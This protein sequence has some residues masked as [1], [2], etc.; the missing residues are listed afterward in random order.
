MDS[1]GAKHFPVRSLPDHTHARTYTYVHTC[2]HEFARL[3][4]RP[5]AYPLLITLEN[6]SLPA[7]ATP[8]F[9]FLTFLFFVCF[10]FLKKDLSKYLDNKSLAFP[11]KLGF[12]SLVVF[13]H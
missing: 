12:F 2:A 8:L 3:W 5:Q 1:G 10:F 11:K 6:K 7:H 4:S 9:S 13:A